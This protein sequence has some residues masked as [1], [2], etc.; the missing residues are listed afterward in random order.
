[1]F[2]MELVLDQRLT[3]VLEITM[4]QPL[5]ITRTYITNRFKLKL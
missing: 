5:G 2:L 4:R 3:L 1:M